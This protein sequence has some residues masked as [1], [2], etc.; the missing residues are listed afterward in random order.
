MAEWAATFGARFEEV[1]STF[2]VSFEEDGQFSTD[3][4]DVIE[5]EHHYD[6]YPGPYIVIPKAWQDQTLATNGKNMEDDV[7]V[8][9]VPYVEVSNVYGTTVSIATE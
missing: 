7:M 2:R 3:F 9:E 6:P 1:G 4:G 5:V 8:T